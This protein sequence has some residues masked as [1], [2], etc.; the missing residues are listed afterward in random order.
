MYPDSVPAR[1]RDALWR[2]DTH[3][4]NARSVVK[5]KDDFLRIYE[6]GK[7]VLMER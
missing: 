4:A 3:M 5:G 7:V 6:G 1:D 2:P